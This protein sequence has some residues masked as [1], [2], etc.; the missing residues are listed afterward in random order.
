M[1]ARNKHI[2][3]KWFGHI[4]LVCQLK[5]NQSVVYKCNL[6]YSDYKSNYYLLC[7]R[8]CG[9]CASRNTNIQLY[10]E[11]SK[12]DCSCRSY[13]PFLYRRGGPGWIWHSGIWRWG[14]RWP[15][16][17]LTLSNARTSLEYL[18]WSDAFI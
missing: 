7:P 1:R 15:S 18:C 9:R 11:Y 5:W 10:R 4:H 3:S 16:S 13:V 17:R 14:L 12:L 6:Y 8:R 2:N